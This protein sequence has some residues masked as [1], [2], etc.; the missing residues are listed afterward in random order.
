MK[1]QKKIHILLIDDKKNV[2]T[3]RSILSKALIPEFTFHYSSCA[4]GVKRKIVSE[5]V[6]VIFFGLV[7]HD[8]RVRK[9]IP[10]LESINIPVIQLIDSEFPKSRIK[11]SFRY[12]LLRS[13]LDS[14]L[15]SHV[16]QMLSESKIC[17][18]KHA[19]V[20]SNETRFLNVLLNT[21]DGIVVTDCNRK[22]LFINPA[23]KNMLGF[24]NSEYFAY[25]T[26]QGVT[27]EIKIVNR[28]NR[29][30]IELCCSQTVW[31][32]KNALLFTLKD[33]TA[34]KQI[35]KGLR[36]SEQRYAYAIRGTKDGLWDW[37]LV[38]E[39]IYYCDQWKSIIGYS[40][41]E[42]GENVQEWFSRI[43]EHDI[44][45]VKKAL[46][47]H[48]CGRL[49][50]FESEHRL[51][52][53]NG[54][55]FWVHAR[56]TA[57]RNKSGKAIR[58]AGSL[59]DIT[60][61][62]GAETQLKKALEELR[63][64]LASEKILM[65]ELDKKNKEL[66]ELSITDGLTSL[67]NHRFIQERFNF[68]FKRVQRYGGAL[69]CLILDIDHFK[70]VNDTFGH[71][72]GDY[73]IRQIAS[74]IKTKSREVDICG[75]YG[76]EEFMVLSNLT[77]TNALKYAAKLHSAIE[78]YKF[79]CNDKTVRITVSIGI[80]EYQK[81]IKTKQEMIERADIALY[82]AKKDGRNLI[83]LW[84]SIDHQ[85]NE[86]IA[87]NEIKELKHKFQDLSIKMRNTY[88]ESINALIKAVD[89]KDPLACEHSRNVSVYSVE[90][91][92]YL[93]LSE[94][95]IEIIRSAALLHDIGKI[96]IRDQILLKRE[97]LTSKE[98]EILKRH[99]EIG[100][101]IL[102][103]LKFL[104]KEIPIILYHHER[105][106]G[107]G[108]PHGLKGREIPIGARI[109]AAADAFDAMT[110]GRIY[111]KPLSM[112]NAC[113]EILGGSATQFAPDI[114]DA[115]LQLIKIGKIRKC[116][117]ERIRGIK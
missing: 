104:E 26:D 44:R 20:L 89:A 45:K 114:V 14:L 88:M 24:Q 9:I 58:I 103:E 83:R 48:L 91:A 51:K 40:N 108:Y 50:Q 43:H 63:F 31:D 84:K 101:S 18:Q 57:V 79:T 96:S 116:S 117:R 42:I 34:R 2:Y 66:I 97:P 80:A 54:N 3:M 39:R 8:I 71:Q 16:I 107:K 105:Y 95:D 81:N 22:I 94:P 1:T 32:N 93:K 61:R 87:V 98:M 75:R 78:S 6:D 115:L 106:D 74:I 17:L 90:I 82:Q 49:E 27:K 102:K 85:D 25:S 77:G 29:K 72:F 33:I 23:A 41:E 67:Y 62:K 69:S 64:A 10:I 36:L 56:G 7:P 38:K 15:I 60:E 109:V 100:V 21:A 73:V 4:S 30:N 46:Q 113:K 28:K 5:S 55:W 37:D 19:S 110:C 53:K 35:E 13:S 65:E 12:R 111:K 52:H 59:T 86:S 99:P 47:D 76:G 112:K 70:H 68:E 92:R 11:F